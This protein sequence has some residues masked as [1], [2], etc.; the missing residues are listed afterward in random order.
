MADK[1]EEATLEEELELQLR[2]QNDSLRDLTEALSSDP[3][4]LELISVQE[5]LI[6]SVKEVEEGLLHLKQARLLREVDASMQCSKSFS[7][8]AVVESLDTKDAVALSDVGQQD[9]NDEV[10]LLVD[11]KYSIGSKCRFRFTDGRWYNGLIVQLEGSHSALVSFLT[12]TSESMLMCQFFL[13]KRC[14][15][16]SSCRLSH[17]I[18]VPISSL[19]KFVPAV[20][21]PS[22][23]GYCIWA[24]EEGKNGLWREA[25]LESWDENLK[26]GHVV[27]RDTG[28]SSK[29]GTEA[30]TLS[31]HAELSDEDEETSSGSTSSDYDQ[32]DVDSAALPQGLGFLESTN[33]QSGIQTEVTLFAKWENHT[34]GVASKMMANMGY[35]EGMGL[36]SAGQGMLDPISV[37]VLPS[38]QSLDHAFEAQRNEQCNG[39]KKEKKRSRGGKRKR[40]KK[41]AEAA[42]AAKEE[43]SKSDMFALIN[44]QLSVHAEILRGTK[45]HM[46]NNNNNNSK[47]KGGEEAKREGG[48][49]GLLAYEDEIKELKIRVEKLE[50]MANRNRREKAVYDA[51]LRKLNETRSALADAEAAR[52]CASTQL[53]TKE[54]EKRW[55]KF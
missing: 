24:L 3:S 27:F 19:K 44:S 13:Q 33:Q 7:E 39:P 47:E 42:R 16:G 38:K 17:G 48:R 6:Q 45:K 18:D 54:K 2:E 5:E 4:N 50:E 40:E 37:R 9:L 35:Q 32:E 41:Y 53:L 29:L 23:V 10:E 11:Q 36:G 15:F 55:L 21:G 22:M 30:I 31:E 12:P 43:G 46:K 52:T 28:I 14:R 8:D 25:E 20:W 51:V 26:L 49:R 1:E 34:R